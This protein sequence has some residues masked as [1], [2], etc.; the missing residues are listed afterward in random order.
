[1]FEVV[2]KILMYMDT[3]LFPPRR[4]W[5]TKYFLERSY[6]RWV[7]NQIIDAIVKNR[8]VPANIIIKDLKDRFRE[9]AISTDDREKNTIFHIAEETANDI[10]QMLERKNEDG[11]A[12]N[13]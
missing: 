5:E 7:V 12:K 10:L 4:T 8:D 6:S 3:F 13:I 9:L 11:L 2:F 1:M